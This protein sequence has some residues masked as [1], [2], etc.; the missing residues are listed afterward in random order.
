MDTAFET[1]NFMGW[2]L[3]MIGMQYSAGPANI[4]IATSVGKSGFKGSLP[5]LLGLWIPAIVYSLAIG[6][7]FNAINGEFTLLF[8]S[9]TLLGTLYIFYLGF[10]FFRASSTVSND[11][12]GTS[13]RFRDGFILSAFNGK[14]LAVILV[15]Y[16]VGLT[17]Q[18]NG[19]TILV[20]TLLFFLNGL[21]ANSI[22]GFGGKLFST[23]MG[24]G[25]LKLQNYIY[26]FLLIGV[27]LWMLYLLMDKYSIWN[28]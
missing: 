11:V 4:L 16:S 8:D 12:E 7:G 3:L 19:Y 2:F 10:K 20:I 22:W 24:T 14:L 27:A 28:L 5:M 21:I 17:E 25:K 18:S 9:L 6:F 13:I 23:L 26:G 15:M 1:F